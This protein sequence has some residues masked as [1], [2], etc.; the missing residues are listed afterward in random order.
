M[1]ELYRIG[2]AMIAI[3]AASS[4]VASSYAQDNSAAEA[5][6]MLDQM[7]AKA[8]AFETI[9]IEFS[10]TTDDKKTSTKEVHQGS[11]KVKGDKYVMDVCD[12]VTFSDS[13][14]VSVW[15]K[16]NNELDISDIDEDDSYAMTPQRLLGAYDKGYNLR[17]M[18]DRTVGMNHYTEIDLYPTD[19]KSNIVRIRISVD[20][21]THKLKKLMQQTKNGVYTTVEIT[22]FETNKAMDD[23]LFRFDKGKHPEVEIVDLR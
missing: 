14:S 6:Q 1:K 19:T 20:S 7:A 17:L 5:R 22:K 10:L 8:K 18:G 2:I 23:S 21:R 12:I 13:K 15:Q 9:D 16:K 4:A 3:V 11:L